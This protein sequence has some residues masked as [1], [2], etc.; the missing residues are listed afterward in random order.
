[1]TEDFD[2]VVIGGGPADI[3]GA[4]TAAIFGKRV[5]LV[6]KLRESEGPE[7]TQERS[8]A[9]PCAKL[10]WRFPVS[11]EIVHHLRKARDPATD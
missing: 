8:R 2:V 10:R 3:C 5:A 9:R 7:S 1:M 11:L 4:N 6:E